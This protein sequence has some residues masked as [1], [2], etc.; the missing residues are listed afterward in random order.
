[1]P[2]SLRPLRRAAARLAAVAFVAALALSPAAVHAQTDDL[3]AVL[4]K[5]QN[6]ST[7]T[8]LLSKYPK[9]FENLP[10][11]GVTILVPTD[12]AFVKF[13]SW[14]RGDA[15]YA[16][17]LLQYHMLQGK[18]SIGS[19]REGSSI[20]VPTLLTDSKYTNVSGGAEMIINRQRDTSVF[21]SGLATRATL[22]GSPDVPFKGGAV[23]LI[24]SVLAM[25]ARFERTARES[26]NGDIDSFLGALYAAG[27]L[28]EFA[29]G[30]NLTV[31][32]PRNAAMARVG[33]ALQAM[34]REQLARVLRHHLV[35]GRVLHGT[36]LRNGTE[37]SPAAGAGAGALRVTLH[38]N[39]IF[40][41]AA[42][43][44]STN[45]LVA[46]GIVHLLDDVLNPDAAADARVNVTAESRP[47]L[48]SATGA[49]AAPTGAGAVLP[50][51]HRAAVRH[52]LTSSSSGVAGR[53]FAA[54]P[55]GMAGV[56]VGM[57]V[58]LA[59]GLAGMEA[60]GAML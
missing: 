47:P 53:V 27:V 44:A 21:I 10:S 37:I 7:Y 46:N 35:P 56:G 55:T 20:F 49:D 39:D 9:I 59:M 11:S 18:V 50:F 31:F 12:A 2:G 33:G 30:A 38:N 26:F 45:F 22:V 43:V 41:G 58:G 25:P 13:Q 14:D 32:A 23:Q 19:I 51:H 42:K 5:Q 8:S 16:E 52:R 17:K 40:I 28:T 36:D 6:V 57:G 3:A 48:F 29:D 4:S 60:V 15:A 34:S 24:D 1:M 54:R